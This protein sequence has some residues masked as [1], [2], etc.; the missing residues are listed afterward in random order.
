MHR[1]TPARNRSKRLQRPRSS[2][3]C[4]TGHANREGART[5]RCVQE[6]RVVAPGHAVHP[7]SPRAAGFAVC[8]GLAARAFVM[9]RAWPALDVR[10]AAQAKLLTGGAALELLARG[11]RGARR[12]RRA[13]GA[14]GLWRRS[15]HEAASAPAPAPAT[16]QARCT[17]R[18]A[19]SCTR[20][21]THN[22]PRAA[23]SPVVEETA[24]RGSVLCSVCARVRGLGSRA[25]DQ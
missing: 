7:E 18:R 6:A 17:L 5:G 20:A 3:S 22:K 10:R 25:M 2:R 12:R 16:V 1:R 11:R 21:L 8:A 4:A 14:H 23:L 13:A 24:E 9:D 19:H 15:R